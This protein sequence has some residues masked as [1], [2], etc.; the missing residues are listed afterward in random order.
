M[1]KVP[2]VANVIETLPKVSIVWV[3]CTNVTDDRQTDGRTMIAKKKLNRRWDSERE[4]Y[5]RRHHTRT[6]KYNKACINS[7]MHR[8]TRLEH[9]FTEFSKITQCNG[10]Y[11]V[12]GHR[13]WY[14]SKAH[15]R[16]PI[17]DYLILTYI[18]TPFPSYGWFLVKFSLARAERL[19][20]TLSLRV[21]LCQ[22]RHKWYIAKN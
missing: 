6:T 14:Q 15:I 2:N 11:A 12:Q 4:L 20:L 19:T 17:S 18:L 8:S 9:R 5:L 10:H 1:A 13:F 7:A 3:G 22:Y 16:F 21:I